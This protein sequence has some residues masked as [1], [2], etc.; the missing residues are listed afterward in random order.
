VSWISAKKLWRAPCAVEGGWMQ[1][2]LERVACA[3]EDD[4]K[5]A[6]TLIPKLEG[7]WV[8]GLPILSREAF[9]FYF[10]P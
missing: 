6:S 7:V 3:L 5:G 10:A 4:R 2:V 9:T 1:S 8:T